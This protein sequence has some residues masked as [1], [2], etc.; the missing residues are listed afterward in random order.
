LVAATSAGTDHGSDVGFSAARA[1]AH[2]RPALNAFSRR[3]RAFVDH[4]HDN[5]SSVS[6]PQPHQ[7]AFGV[8][9][10]G[11]APQFRGLK[12][13]ETCKPGTRRALCD[14]SDVAVRDRSA[15]PP[16]S[17]PA[18]PLAFRRKLRRVGQVAPAPL[19]AF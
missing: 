19:L 9:T 7:C 8:C 14:R 13:Y 3:T 18:P 1:D 5:I 4:G 10:D 15:R 2:V 12:V 11:I 16:F 6:R 17:V